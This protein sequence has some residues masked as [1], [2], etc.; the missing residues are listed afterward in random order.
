MFL[1]RRSDL[2]SFLYWLMIHDVSIEQI[3]GLLLYVWVYFHLVKTLGRILTHFPR[4]RIWIKFSHDKCT[5]SNIS[6]HTILPV[7]N[8]QSQL[9]HK[10]MW[11]L[12]ITL[13]YQ[14]QH[15]SLLPFPELNF[16][17]ELLETL[18]NLIA[19]LSFV[20]TTDYK[21]LAC[22]NKFTP[23]IA[24]RNNYSKFTTYQSRF[25]ISHMNGGTK[26]VLDRRCNHNSCSILS[27]LVIGRHVYTQRQNSRFCQNS[28]MTSS[29]VTHMLG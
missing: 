4:E 27:S 26:S 18:D 24:S 12:F 9:L 13:T 19:C 10:P 20:L 22:A 2:L 21:Y 28:I 16:L 1:S 8:C 5:N 15:E 17:Q 11:F 23:V 25:A 3:P 14:I 6:L 29:C 7:C